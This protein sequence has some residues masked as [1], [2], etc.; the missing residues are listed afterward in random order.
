MLDLALKAIQCSI[1]GTF[2]NRVSLSLHNKNKVLTSTI[3]ATSIPNW[4]AISSVQAV[5]YVT[6]HGTFPAFRNS[7]IVVHVSSTVS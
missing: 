1:V 6:G 7:P 3:R 2:L 5:S 4:S